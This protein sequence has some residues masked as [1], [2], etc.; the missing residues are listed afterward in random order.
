MHQRSLSLEEEEALDFFKRGGPHG[1]DGMLLTEGYVAEITGQ[2][3]YP[4]QLV[5]VTADGR[6][7]AYDKTGVCIGTAKDDSHII[8]SGG[9]RVDFKVRKALGRA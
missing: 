8:L 7:D 9:I 4:G 6:L 5:F 3:F 1:A 2:G